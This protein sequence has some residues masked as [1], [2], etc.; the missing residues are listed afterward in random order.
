MSNVELQIVDERCQLTLTGKLDVFEAPSLLKAAREAVDA[1]RP[2][3]IQVTGLERMDASI[4]QILLVLQQEAQ[5]RGRSLQVV[6]ARPSLQ[7][8]GY[9][10]GGDRSLFHGAS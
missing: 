2:I 10:L 4:F 6:G 8:I 9:L 5:R 1:A 7:R 3:I